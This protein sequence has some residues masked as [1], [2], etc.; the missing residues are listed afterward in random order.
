MGKRD[1]KRAELAERLA[2]H[3][4]MHGLAGSSLRPLAEA[5]GLSDRMLVYYFTDKNGILETVCAVISR[6]LDAILECARP[7]R[8][9]TVPDLRAHLWHAIP[10]NILRLCLDLAIAASHGNAAAG[11]GASR[12]GRQISSFAAAH[13]NSRSRGA[14]SARLMAELFGMAAGQAS[15]LDALV[16]AALRSEA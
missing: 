2:D 10:G 14:D 11:V 15:G 12:L 1:T 6:R 8:P 7:Q 16:G 9:L 3:V 13:V 4:L 5:A